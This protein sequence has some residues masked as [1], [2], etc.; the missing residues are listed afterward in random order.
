MNVHIHS[1]SGVTQTGEVINDG[2]LV[3]GDHQRIAEMQVASIQIR[4]HS[5]GARGA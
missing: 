5:T 3:S 1:G 4:C 2:L